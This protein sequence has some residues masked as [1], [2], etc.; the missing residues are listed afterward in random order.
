MHKFSCLHYH[1]ILV[2]KDFLH[3]IFSEE[4]TIIIPNNVLG[5]TNIEKKI[6]R[7]LDNSVNV[8]FCFLFCMSNLNFVQLHLR[9]CCLT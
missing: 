8:A 6:H 4:A 2:N 3:K 9:Y 5:F 1:N 7:A